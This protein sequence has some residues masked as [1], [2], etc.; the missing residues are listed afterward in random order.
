MEKK[1]IVKQHLNVRTR[2]KKSIFGCKNSD[3][4]ADVEYIYFFNFI[5]QISGILNENLYSLNDM[6]WFWIIKQGSLFPDQIICFRFRSRKKYICKVVYNNYFSSDFET[7]VL[8]NLFVQ[9]CVLKRENNT[10][11]QIKNLRNWTLR[12]N[13]VGDVITAYWWRINHRVS[14]AASI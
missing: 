9:K 11:H 13:T 5:I 14:M 4:V 8:W 12:Q 1:S 2:T 7:R 10:Q 6:K 3:D